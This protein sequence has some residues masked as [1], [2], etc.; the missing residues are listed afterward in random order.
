MI[1]SKD[2]YFKTVKRPYPPLWSSLI[3]AG[4][5]SKEVHAPFFSKPYGR[6]DSLLCDAVWYYNIETEDYAR[7][8]IADEWSNQDV[9]KKV[10]T[11]IKKREKNLLD[12]IASPFPELTHAYKQY[13]VALTLAYLAEQP[14]YNLLKQ[15]LM[16]HVSEA[17]ANTLLDILNIPLEDNYHK[18]EELDLIQSSNI[19]DHV[20]K[21]EWFLSRYGSNVP[22]TLKD[23][24][25]K[26][27]ELDKNKYLI[28]YKETK[29][30]V[31]KAIN[32]AKSIIGEQKAF[33][34]DGMQFI[35]FYRTHRTDVMNRT[36]YMYIPTLTKMA[37]SFGITYEDILFCTEAEVLS[38]K[39]PD[40]A[41]LNERKKGHMI[42]VIDD[43]PTC[44]VGEEFVRIKK[45]FE[46]E[47]EGSKEIKGSIAFKGKVTG[48]V[49]VIHSQSDLALV[50][51]GDIIVAAMT[52]PEM[53]PFMKLSIGFITDEGGI[54]CHAAIVAR[55]MKKP[56]I[57]GTKIATQVLKDGMMVEVDAEKGIVKILK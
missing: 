11:E 7:K 17:E 51:E 27:R 29:E 37:E 55:E 9:I 2:K 41:I 42:A 13:M 54:T 32:E 8:L 57:I 33:L 19:E 10:I 1:L 5:I 23:A 40:I 38:N 25:K 53:V 15:A 14:F 22:Y 28:E 52:T 20:K 4:S 47:S 34:V 12:A 26:I 43:V 36:S 44:I 31:T 21:Y 46:A 24:E 56:C 18:Q 3:I 6:S 48:K 16:E 30:K 35:V 39:I 50:T 45:E 49:K